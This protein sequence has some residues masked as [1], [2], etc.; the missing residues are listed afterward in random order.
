MQAIILTHT[1]PAELC[2][3]SVKNS[4]CSLPFG[5]STVLEN[6]LHRFMDSD[7]SD[8]LITHKESQTTYFE[9][10]TAMYRECLPP[11]VYI[12][13][14]V[15]PSGCSMTELFSRIRSHITM[16]YVFL[17]Y[18]TTVLTDLDLRSVF[19]SLIRNN[20]AVTAVFC[21]LPCSESKHFKALPR[22][23]VITSRSG[24]QLLGHYSPAD[25]KKQTSIPRSL[26]SQGAAFLARTDLRDLRFYLLTKSTIEAFI[27]LRE[28]FP[29]K[30]KTIWQLI[31][32]ISVDA[33]GTTHTASD[34]P[35]ENMD[36]IS[37]QVDAFY[38][39]NKKSS[40]TCMYEHK[41]QR[42]SIQLN[43]PLSFVEANRIVSPTAMLPI[44]SIIGLSLS[45][46]SN[47]VCTFFTETC[48]HI[49]LLSLLCWSV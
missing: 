45:R 17:T 27:R 26:T 12:K 41:T 40:G 21:G 33:N 11:H 2:Q 4:C 14:V 36:R 44:S 29:H 20:A 48:F 28:D 37:D 32:L 16:D 31:D 42:I 49:Q 30:K 24:T 7:I 1:E 35:E 10:L 13:L 19:L 6:L 18:S 39:C 46:A 22:E 3:L 8:I 5:S 43:D 25:I 38:R 34:S 15:M 23:V 47:R 9:Q